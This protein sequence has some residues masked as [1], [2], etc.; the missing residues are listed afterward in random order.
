MKYLYL[1]MLTLL[2]HYIGSAQDTIRKI[3][4][5]GDTA[6]YIRYDRIPNATYDVSKYLMTHINYPQN[7]KDSFTNGKVIIKFT[8][9]TNGSITNARMIKCIHPTIDSIIKSVILGM[10]KWEP[11]EYNG[12]KVVSQY[13]LPINIHYYDY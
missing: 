11:A 10:P 3:N 4:Q 12:K 13:T 1:F 8:I 5:N 7:L 2:L 9:E 6:L